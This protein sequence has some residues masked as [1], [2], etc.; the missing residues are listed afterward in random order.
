M[1]K[2]VVDATAF[3]N[4]VWRCAWGGQG[5]GSRSGGCTLNA[6]AVQGAM[7]GAGR[8]GHV[9]PHF[10]VLQLLVLQLLV[11]QLLVLQLLVHS[12]WCFRDWT[13]A[14]VCPHTHTLSLV[15]TLFLQVLQLMGLDPTHSVS[16]LTDTLSPSLQVLQVMGLDP[17]TSDPHL[18]HMAKDFLLVR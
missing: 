6:G 16:T 1:W 15:P 10:L 17:A 13:P 7:H 2:L 18:V 4:V 8:G 3:E 14:R 11:L 9:S 12:S 5:L